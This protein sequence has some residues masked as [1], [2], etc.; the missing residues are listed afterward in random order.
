[1]KRNWLEWIVLSASAVVIL[2]LVGVIAMTGLS[3]GDR[4]PNPAVEL[5]PDAGREAANGWIVAGTVRNDGDVAAEAIVLEASASVGG[6]TEMSEAGVDY[7]P[8][9]TE[10]DIEFGFTGRPDGEISVRVVSMRP[11]T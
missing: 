9:G 3:G 10:V 5:R 1:M 4:P 2:V 6:E 8:P 11:S 7:L